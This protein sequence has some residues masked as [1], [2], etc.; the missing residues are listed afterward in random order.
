MD[1]FDLLTMIGGLCLFLFGMNIMGEALERS[2]GNK[3]RMLLS[4]LTSSKIAGLLTGLCITALIQSSSATTVLVVGFVNSGLMTLRQAIHVIMGANIGTT[5]TAWI[6]SLTGIQSSNFFIKMLKPSSFAPILAFIGIILYL[7]CKSS[8]KKEIGLILLGFTTLIFGMESMSGAV[9]QL[10]QIPPFQNILILFK[11]PFLGL[12]AGAFLTAVIQSSSASIGILQALS[13][14][15]KI[16]YEAAVPIIMGQNIGT[17]IT[18]GL[19]SIG[20]NKN[21]KRAALIH[22]LF[23][24]IGA[25]ILLC[26]FCSAKP[27][28]FHSVL[29][30]PVKSV[31]IAL[32]HTV[33][34][35][36]STILMIPF[37]SFL[38]KLAISCIR[39]SQKPEIQIELDERLLNTPSIALNRCSKIAA[40]L[41]ETSVSIVKD[42]VFSYN[43]YSEELAEKIRTKEKKTDHYEDILNTYLIRLSTKQVNEEIASKAAEL[44]KIISDFERI[45][46]H[47]INLLKSSE[48]LRNKN[49]SLSKEAKEEFDLITAAVFETSE[50][51]LAAFF[52]NDI[53]IAKK[54]EPLEQVIDNLKR[55]MR[56]N[57]IQRLQGEKCSIETGFIYSDILTDLE[58]ISDH[59]SNIAGCIMEIQ[60]KN[61]NLHESLH[62]FRNTNEDFRQDL[63][64]YMNKY[65]LK[66][67][68]TKKI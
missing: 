3:L 9:S 23:N 61:L 42:S 30:A 13:V 54:I 20:A 57:H 55:E 53:N 12:A 22:F 48:E 11:N 27:L 36:L 24:A 29:N 19:S 40:D 46:D 8:K 43:C 32:I 67:I 26:I 62:N 2:A 47:G 37:T 15:G 25:V 16:S 68:K 65:S 45:A 58:R 64:K 49:A 60:N 52:N 17:C 14:T 35:L 39:E 38:E 33:F 51:T 63:I 34:N 41:A 50:H 66:R 59:C 31:D 5:V 1:I 56:N 18:A 10:G 21:A 44:I 7:F 4:K 6:L 28:I